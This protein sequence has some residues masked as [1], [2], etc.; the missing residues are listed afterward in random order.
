[1]KYPPLARAA[2]KWDQLLED[3]R[4]QVFL[5]IAYVLL[6]TIG[7][8]GMIRE[9]PEPVM[10]GW[11]VVFIVLFFIVNA[12]VGLVI[13]NREV[14]LLWLFLRSF[15]TWQFLYFV[16]ET[17]PQHTLRT[18]FIACLFSVYSYYLEFDRKAMTALVASL[19]LVASDTPK[20]RKYV[21]KGE[22]ARE[23]QFGLATLVLSILGGWKIYRWFAL[24]GIY[25][26]NS[27]L[28]MADFI[29]SAGQAELHQMW[30]AAA[31]TP[32]AIIY[33]LFSSDGLPSWFGFVYLALML[34][35]LRSNVPNEGI[36]IVRSMLICGLTTLLELFA[37][38]IG[39]RFVVFTII[40][41]V[42]LIWMA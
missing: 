10:R 28:L 9:H 31:T 18:L 22:R 19:L 39:A 41:L 26:A 30:L 33:H 5:R 32:S 38:G 35:F 25:L 23:V 34:L 4:F 11:N 2:E 3:F 24:I 20:L 1:M 13:S 21:W 40:S 7:M 37:F 12:V 42:Y 27:A 14:K 29:P 6:S 17:Y 15:S 36:V 8:I 16:Y